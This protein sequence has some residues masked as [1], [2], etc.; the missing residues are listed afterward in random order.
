MANSLGS[1]A[2]RPLAGAALEFNRS[3]REEAWENTKKKKPR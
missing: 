3:A 2:S 1:Q